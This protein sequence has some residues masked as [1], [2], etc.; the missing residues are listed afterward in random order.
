[1]PS[2]AVEGSGVDAEERFADGEVDAQL[3]QEGGLADAGGTE[4]KADPAS[5]EE[6]LRDEFG[7]VVRRD[8]RVIEFP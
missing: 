2:F 7:G 3:H 4:Q 6:A 8:P 5:V 1:M